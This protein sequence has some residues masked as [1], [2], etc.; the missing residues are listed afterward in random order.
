MKQERYAK[1]EKPEKQ[2]KM[3]LLYRNLL[4]L[5]DRRGKHSLHVH[6][7]EVNVLTF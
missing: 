5:T 4:Q 7:G 1:L 2:G 3:N 6:D